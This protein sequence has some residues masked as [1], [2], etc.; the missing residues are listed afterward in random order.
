MPSFD[1]RLEAPANGARRTAASHR[2]APRFLVGT[3]G[4]RSLAS[5]IGVALLVYP[6]AL[7]GGP[8]RVAL[9]AAAAGIC[10]VVVVVRPAGPIIAIT[11]GMLGTEYALAVASEGVRADLFAPVVAV[12]W[13]LFLEL[14]DL[15]AVWTEGAVP[16]REVV[17]RRLAGTLAVAIVG[18]LVA[19]LGL[20]SRFAVGEFGVTATVVGAAC[21]LAALAIPVRLA[22]RAVRGSDLP[23]EVSPPGRSSGTA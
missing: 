5:A 13:Y 6:L 1:S 15:A 20:V 21:V 14:L 12:L 4:I 19:A 18:G 11:A 10:L 22:H 2:G 23:R 3:V 9:L 8:P 7:A 16:H 17:L